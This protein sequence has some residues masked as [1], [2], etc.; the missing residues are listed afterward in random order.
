MRM[1]GLTLVI[2]NK[3][4]SS[5]SLRPWLLLKHVGAPFKE[6]RIP[7]YGEGTRS[8]IL[9][10]SPSGHVPALLDGDLCVWDSLAICEYVADLFPQAKVWPV[11][12]NARAVARSIASEM[13]S[14]FAALR[15]ELPMNCRGPRSGVKATEMAQADIDRI[16]RAGRSAASVLEVKARGCSVI[17]APPMRCT[18]RSS[19]AFTP[20]AFPCPRWPRSM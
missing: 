1:H 3:N 18:R 17:S 8:E 10:Y 5:W 4:Y 7:L 15:F 20:T 6:I 14:G 16:M 2:G 13:H 9:R 19:F 11:E 12:R